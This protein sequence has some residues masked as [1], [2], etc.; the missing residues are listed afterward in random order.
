MTPGITIE[1]RLRVLLPN[2]AENY[3]RLRDRVLPDLI[4]QL[5]RAKIL[6]TNF[7]PFKA[8]KVIEPNKL[9]KEILGSDFDETPAQMVNRVCRELGSKRNIVVITDEAH[10]CYRRK[11]DGEAETLKGEDRTEAEKRNEE[12]RVWISGLEAVRDQIGIRGFY[13][14]SATPLFRTTR[15]FSFL[16]SY[17]YSATSR[18]AAGV[19]T[20][21]D[22]CLSLMSS[23]TADGSSSWPMIWRR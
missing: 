12:A 16:A 13:D 9:T 22:R 17:R 20:R 11:P 5:G 18:T 19:L 23:T 21:A 14:L 6:I 10:H 8:R 2:D 1:D 7:H 15:R 4:G 3:F